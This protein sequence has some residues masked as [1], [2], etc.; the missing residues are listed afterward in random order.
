MAK[1]KTLKITC[2][3]DNV[4]ERVS[5]WLDE[6]WSDEIKEKNVQYA[7]GDYPYVEVSGST[8]DMKN[9]K[10]DAQE[11]FESSINAVLVP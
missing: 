8:K 3:D 10:D 4:L 7:D 11:V 6:Y 2:D 9:L 5:D 1:L